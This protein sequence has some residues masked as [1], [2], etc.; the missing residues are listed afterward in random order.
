MPRYCISCDTPLQASWRGIC[1]GWKADGFCGGQ[2]FVE[3]DPP[4]SARPLTQ[5]SDDVNVLPVPESPL[6]NVLGG[7][8]DGAVILVLGPGGVGKSTAVAHL[9]WHVA[10]ARNGR[11]FW[12]NADQHETLVKAVFLRTKTP[13]TN[14]YVEE[15]NADPLRIWNE[16]RKNDVIVVDSLQ[17]WVRTANPAEFLRSIKRKHRTTFVIARVNAAG[18]VAGPT[19]T[20]HEVDAV[21]YMTAEAFEVPDKCR[22]TPTPRRIERK[23]F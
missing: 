18:H 15:N 13:I 9:S 11:V 14:V 2:Y 3:K 8:A 22:W 6:A 5:V 4:T 10:R 7:V 21:V 16:T 19:E 17:P 1:Q 12:C 23:Q 20:E